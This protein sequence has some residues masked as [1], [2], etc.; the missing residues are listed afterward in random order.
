MAG[1]KALWTGTEMLVWVDKRLGGLR[2]NPLTD[3][4]KEIS[5]IGAPEPEPDP[6]GVAQWGELQTTAVWT[7]SEMIVWDGFQAIGGRYNPLTDTWRA[8]ATQGDALRG[9]Q[10]TQPSGQTLK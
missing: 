4:W 1:H 8:V 3:T 9:V 7:G 5:T 10:N 2:Y 6:F